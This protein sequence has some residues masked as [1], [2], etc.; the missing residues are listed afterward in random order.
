[1]DIQRDY[2]DVRSI[3]D[4]QEYSE[5]AAIVRAWNRARPTARSM[6]VDVVDIEGIK[7]VEDI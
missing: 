2:I 3:K 6:F 4:D 7:V 1:M 5:Y